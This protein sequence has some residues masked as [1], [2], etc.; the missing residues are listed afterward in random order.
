VKTYH[1]R[2]IV[3]LVSSVDKYFQNHVTLN[4]GNGGD[5]MKVEVCNKNPAEVCTSREI[6][7]EILVNQKSC[8]FT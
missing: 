1:P 8:L 5:R 3:L 6:I 7:A 2:G 4:T